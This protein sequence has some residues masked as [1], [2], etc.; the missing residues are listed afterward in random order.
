MSDLRENNTQAVEPAISG[1][2]EGVS[3]AFR[4][5]KFITLTIAVLFVILTLSFFREDVSI[6]NFQYMLKYITSEEDTLITTQK[7]H[8]PTSDSKALTLFNGDLVSAGTGGISLYDTNGSSVLQIDEVYSS[9]YFSI[10]D[11]YGLCY[12]MSGHSFVIFS[13]FAKLYSEKL[14]YPISGAKMTD[15]G[16]YVIMTRDREYKTVFNVYNSDYELISRVFKDNYTFAFDYNGKYLAYASVGASDSRFVCELS[17]VKANSDS[18]ISKLTYYD[19]FP[20]ALK[21]MNGSLAFLTD[22]ALRFYNDKVEVT[23][24]YSVESQI[25]GYSFAD[26][27]MMIYSEKN[28]IGSENEARFFSDKGKLISSQTVKGKI[29]SVAL[30]DNCSLIL[31]NNTV[32]RID[33]DSCDVRICKIDTGADTALLQSDY[34]A[35]VCYDNF[36]QLVDFED[37]NEIYKFGITEG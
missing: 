5:A 2:Y 4:Y 16:G 20:V 10:G 34:T 8:Y 7:L 1:Y 24:E 15:K 14:D 25:S 22:K 35:L 32:M 31:T 3:V 11:R 29:N 21:Y 28:I 26:D 19:E 23:Q 27:F 33:F 37:A 17:V 18:E 12:D 9:P 36:A 6:E 30:K 13:T